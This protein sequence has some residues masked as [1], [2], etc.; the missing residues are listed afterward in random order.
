MYALSFDRGIMKS[1]GFESDGVGLCYTTNADLGCGGTLERVMSSS[2]E[3]VIDQDTP[4]APVFP[5]SKQVD[6]FNKLLPVV[7]ECTREGVTV[8][9]VYNN[10]GAQLTGL[11]HV[12]GNSFGLV[13][14]LCMDKTVNN[15][16]GDA[17]TTVKA[18]EKSNISGDECTTF[19][20]VEKLN[21]LDIPITESILDTSHVDNTN[22]I[23]IRSSAAER[24]NVNNRIIK[25]TAFKKSLEEVMHEQR[26]NSFKNKT[27]HS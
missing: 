11:C 14:S 17:C 19:K 24:I 27:M 25:P 2:A 12:H 16:C 3:E 21:I 7:Q 8:G 1:C 18:V 23:I 5:G 9:P 10:H 22:H 26:V 15:V 6:V 4:R 20:A 13:V